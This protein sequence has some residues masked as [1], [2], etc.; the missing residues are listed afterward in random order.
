[1]FFREDLLGERSPL[2]VRRGGRDIKKT[3]RSLLV[4]ADGVVAHEPVFGVSDRP[5][6]GAKV[7]CAEIFL[8]PQ[9]PLLTRRGLPSPIWLRPPR[10]LSLCLCGF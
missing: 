1:M 2:L 3:P 9:P 6:C 10:A 4:G 5:V 8:M 7:G